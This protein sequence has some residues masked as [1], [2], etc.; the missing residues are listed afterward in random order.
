MLMY[1]F[2]CTYVYAPT[3]VLTYLLL[4]DVTTDTV[5]VRFSG[6]HLCEL[7]LLISNNFISEM[8]HTYVCVPLKSQFMGNDTACVHAEA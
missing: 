5:F 1:G 8:R 7:H 6:I 3:Y 2:I 4:L